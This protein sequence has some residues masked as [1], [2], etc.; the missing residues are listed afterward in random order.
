MMGKVLNQQLVMAGQ[1]VEAQKLL[2]NTV[3]AVFTMNASNA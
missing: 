3:S 1:M 2:S